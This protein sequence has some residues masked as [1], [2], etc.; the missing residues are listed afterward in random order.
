MLVS[1]NNNSTSRYSL[2][3]CFKTTL[4]KTAPLTEMTEKE[5]NKIKNLSTNFKHAEF[6]FL[7]TVEEAAIAITDTQAANL[8]VLPSKFKHKKHSSEQS[9]IRDFVLKSDKENVSLYRFDD[10]EYNQYKI[11]E[12]KTKRDSNGLSNN[13]K[14]LLQGLEFKERYSSDYE[15]S[16]YYALPLP[17]PDTLVWFSTRSVNALD[18]DKIIDFSL[19]NFENEKVLIV[20][21]THGDRKGNSSI[22]RPAL[23]F[24][25]S[26][27]DYTNQYGALEN[28]TIADL[29]EKETGW[30]KDVIESG[31]Y[32]TIIL[33][34]CLSDSSTELKQALGIEPPKS[35]GQQ[36]SDYF[37]SYL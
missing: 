7:H 27:T 5:K 6:K 26:I 23:G 36:L 19:K 31:E 17:G 37:K 24:G 1:R 20:G 10:T 11:D 4:H 14:N 33:G 30:L 9:T 32:G 12:L 3:N 16:L 8:S 35:C 2:F 13:E 18:C 21:G 29:R 15:N 28:V 22:E 25:E 34:W